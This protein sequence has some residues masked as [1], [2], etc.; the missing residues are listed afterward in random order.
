MLQR[1]TIALPSGVSLAYVCDASRRAVS[2]FV[3]LSP[4]RASLEQ[5]LQG[6]YREAT[7]F[8]PRRTV[9][10]AAPESQGVVAIVEGAQREVRNVV[11]MALTTSG[12]ELARKLPS[13]VHILPATDS[14]GARGFIPVDAEGG[15]LAD[16]VLAL[17]LADYLTRPKD[18]A[19]KGHLLAP[20]PSGERRTSPDAPTVPKMNAVRLK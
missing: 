5:W 15:R 1:R 13:V 11:R 8:G 4:S 7:R 3:T 19:Q 18:F 12:D 2:D 10:L 20:E 14:S 17:V 9:A 16:R 6:R